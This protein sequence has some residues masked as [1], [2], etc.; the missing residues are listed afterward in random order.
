VH[1]IPVEGKP[2]ILYTFNVRLVTCEACRSLPTFK[3]SHKIASNYDRRLSESGMTP[4]DF[5][6]HEHELFMAELAEL[7]EK[8]AEG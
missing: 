5:A 4:E 1:E 7:K 2:S 3:E 8:D 6:K